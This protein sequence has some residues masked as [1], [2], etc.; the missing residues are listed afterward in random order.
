MP[1]VGSPVPHESAHAHV[2]GEAIYI[3]DLPPSCNEL[4]VD[5]VGSSLAHA[6]IVA[7]DVAAA[8][9]IDGVAAVFT[10]DDVP[11][12]NRFGPILHDEE[13]LAAGECHHIGQPIVAIAAN[14]RAALRAARAAVRIELE[15]L[16]AVLT[17]D[18]AVAATRF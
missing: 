6:R 3:D 16:P 10:A 2:T 9:R 12:D 18:E 8:A 13:L 11:G 7:I 17:I 14:S 15:E 5:F 1:L 4:F